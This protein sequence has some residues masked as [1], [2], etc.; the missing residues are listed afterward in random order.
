VDETR[1]DSKVVFEGR[2]LTMKVDTV[3]LPNGRQAS[4]EVVVHPGAVAVT[5]VNEKDEILL[6]KQFRYPAGH[7]L[8]E[9]PAGKLEKGEEPLIC[10]KRELAEETGYGA[11]EWRHLSTFFTTPGFTDE[12]MYVY[13]A[14]GLYE[15]KKAADDDELIELHNV[16]FSAALK[17]ISTGEI[18]D[19]KTIAG[20]LLAD[21]VRLTSDVITPSHALKQEKE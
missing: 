12:I 8:W 11:E 18:K 1:I 10:A 14:T 13:L 7:V 2:M 17:M 5:A 20:I 4:R 9:I 16:P 15:D 19:A 3:K 6:I 21:K